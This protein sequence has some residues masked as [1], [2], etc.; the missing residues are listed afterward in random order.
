[1]W[2]LKKPSRNNVIDIKITKTVLKK[3]K[4]LN[5]TIHKIFDNNFNFNSFTLQL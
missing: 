3:Q 2:G 1:M 4:Y 5:M